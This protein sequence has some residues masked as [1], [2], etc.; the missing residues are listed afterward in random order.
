M[1]DLVKTKYDG[2]HCIGFEYVLKDETD[3]ITFSFEKHQEDFGMT[4]W[5]MYVMLPDVCTDG[6]KRLVQFIFGL[7]KED[8]SLVKIAAI[9]LQLARGLMQKEVTLCTKI[10]FLINEVV[11][12]I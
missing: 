7:P 5:K 1:K 8:L 2:K 6:K 4:S 11:D 12:G 3:E 9:G 10:D